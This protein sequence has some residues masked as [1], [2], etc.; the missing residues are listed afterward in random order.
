M[1]SFFVRWRRRSDWYSEVTGDFIIDPIVCSATIESL[2]CRH[3]VGRTK[4]IIAATTNPKMTKVS[5]SATKT[6]AKPNNSG[7]SAITP[8]PAAPIRACAIPV[9]SAPNPK[10]SPAP[11]AIDQSSTIFPTPMVFFV[12]TASYANVVIPRGFATWITILYSV[13]CALAAY[14]RPHPFTERFDDF[15]CPRSTDGFDVMRC[16]KATSGR[17]LC[18]PPFER[19]VQSAPALIKL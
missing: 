10:A 11:I 19:I 7:F 17:S 4:R 9:P 6:S 18:R 1:S 15:F 16:I 8:A 5:G 2:W 12:S 14:L 3:I 13:A